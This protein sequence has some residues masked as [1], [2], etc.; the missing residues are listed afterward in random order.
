MEM[1][2]EVPSL[3]EIPKI[4]VELWHGMGVEAREVGELIAML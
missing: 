4:F 1:T 2:S 3:S